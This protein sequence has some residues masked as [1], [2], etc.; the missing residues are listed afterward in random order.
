MNMNFLM[1]Q[2]QKMQ[3]DM[4]KAQK[5]LEAKVFDVSSAGGAIKISI[6]GAKKIVSISIDKDIVDPDDVDMLQD[7]LMVA[8][9]EAI[10][11]VVNEEKKI[12]S[13]QQANLRM[14]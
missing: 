6:T 13:A 1:Q 10:T 2:A 3:K 4:E 9:N 11:L 12:L 8:C 7:M 5:E 14:F